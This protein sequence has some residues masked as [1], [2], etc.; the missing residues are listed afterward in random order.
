MARGGIFKEGA[1]AAPLAVSGDWKAGQV[2]EGRIE[3]DEFDEARTWCSSLVAG[4]PDN[5]WST[6]VTFKVGVLGP[7]AMVT[8]FPP[9]VSPEDYDGILVESG[10]FESCEDF[11]H[12]GISVAHTGGV[13]V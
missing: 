8:Q 3:V 10:F 9:M 13:S 2:T 11:S 4:G 12:A 5:E 6:G 7:G 1:E